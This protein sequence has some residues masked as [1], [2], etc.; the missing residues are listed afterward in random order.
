MGY[1]ALSVEPR[2]QL[3]DSAGLAPDFPHG[4]GLFGPWATSALHLFDTLILYTQMGWRS[5]ARMTWCD[6][7]PVT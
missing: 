6:A 4:P 7:W 1:L 5:N 2:L 3:R